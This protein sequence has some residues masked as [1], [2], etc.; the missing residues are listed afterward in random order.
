MLYCLG[1]RCFFC[2]VLVSNDRRHPDT[3][4]S[5]VIGLG[6]ELEELQ[7]LASWSTNRSRLSIRMA[8]FQSS[9]RV[10]L[11]FYVIASSTVGVL[12]VKNASKNGRITYN[13]STVVFCTEFLK[14]I[15][16]WILDSVGVGR[17]SDTTSSTVSQG[18]GTTRSLRDTSS[19]T[20]VAI[21]FGRNL[22]DSVPDKSADGAVVDAGDE[23]LRDFVVNTEE[24]EE[25]PSQL[26]PPTSKPGFWLY[27]VPGL[28]Y[29]LMNNLTLVGVVLL[30]PAI[31]VVFSNLNLLTSAVMGYL[32]LRQTWH[33]LQLLGLVII[34][35]SFI[36]AKMQYFVCSTTISTATTAAA[37]VLSPTTTTLE[38]LGSTTT[39]L[40]PATL[41][42]RALLSV[43]GEQELPFSDGGV[44]AIVSGVAAEGAFIGTTI[45]D[46]NLEDYSLSFNFPHKSVSL[47]N[48]ESYESYESGEI[49]GSSPSESSESSAS[50]KRMLYA[51]GAAVAGPSTSD[52]TGP[53]S[54]ITMTT[55]AAT[56]STQSS[57]WD[58]KVIRFQMGMLVVLTNAC[59]SSSAGVASEFLLKD[60]DA[61]TSIWRKNMWLYGWGIIFNSFSILY[62]FLFSTSDPAA[63]KTGGPSTS[64]DWWDR[65]FRGMNSSLWLYI[66]NGAVQGLSIS[67]VLKYF[68]NM[69]KCVFKVV[70]I[71]SVA[72]FSHLLFGT[73]VGLDFQV[74]CFYFLIGFG[75]WFGHKQVIGETDSVQKPR[76]Y[77]LVS[78]KKD[79]DE[80]N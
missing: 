57:W 21:G 5:C 29:G 49:G 2:W 35:A 50:A 25:P 8:L 76:E 63:A 28:C 70:A 51:G 24:E 58:S 1:E 78:T 62:S 9:W 65:V 22:A 45:W 20:R 54:S 4:E 26:T 37:S 15:V 14:Y 79:V 61:T 39:A 13:T 67:L 18:A 44:G 71:F 66:L 40:P 30:D 59:L 60:K 42:R 73:E 56:S 41:L 46:S 27:A 48:T 31:F 6:E 72:I 19:S 33:R 16:C 36:V 23:E 77:E 12:F 55:Q 74:A 32:F 75:L 52:V 68:G 43:N 69:E 11:A 3:V 47:Q 17:D 7:N 53:S 10:L 34:L 64:G 38:P 80:E